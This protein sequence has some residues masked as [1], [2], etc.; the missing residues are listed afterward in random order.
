V[1]ELSQEQFE[2]ILQFIHAEK[3]LDMFPVVND[4][5]VAALFGITAE[6]YRAVRDKI[7]D[8]ARYSAVELLDEPEFS[9]KIEALPIPAEYTV[10]GVGDSFT[11]DDQSW[12]EILRFVLQ[13]RFSQCKLNIINSGVSTQTSTHIVAR[14]QQII[15]LKPDLVVFF[16]GTNDAQRI[17]ACPDKTLVGIEES[18]KNFELLNKL[19]RS[20]TAA[21]V[22]WFTP[23]GILEDRIAR[24]WMLG[25]T[26]SSWASADVES[27]VERITAIPET[28]VDLT[29]VFGK[30]P[31]GEL[32]LEDGLHPSLAGHKLIV[33]ELIDVLAAQ[34]KMSAA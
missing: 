34:S 15:A 28:V 1:P 32:L 8:R 3:V 30:P 5:T 33:K 12:L 29:Q 21:D 27:V 19:V 7:S 16:L 6:E 10:V 13:S 2:F 9:A 22:V 26:G 18:G 23:T 31:R 24:H 20:E 17:D 4:T 11:D 14:V 25:N